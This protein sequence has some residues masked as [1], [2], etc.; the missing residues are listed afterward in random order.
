[1][2]NLVLRAAVSAYDYGQAIL[3]HRQRE[4][5][6]LGQSALPVAVTIRVGTQ[7]ASE[8]IDGVRPR[9]A[10]VVGLIRLAAPGHDAS[11]GRFGPGDACNRRSLSGKPR[12]RPS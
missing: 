2:Q 6:E 12:G 9:P 1:Q 11:C 7:S 10:D 4:A 3:A 8:K 5:A